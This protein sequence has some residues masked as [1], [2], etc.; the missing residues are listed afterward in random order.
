[1]RSAARLSAAFADVLR[2]HRT[3]LGLSQE[4]LAERAGL[5]A[6]YI[7][8]IERGTRKP[9][10]YVAALLAEALRQPLSRLIGEAE[11]TPRSGHS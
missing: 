6:V 1:M 7:S 9:T 4:A 3:R 5:H 11:R 8:M 2:R 10:V